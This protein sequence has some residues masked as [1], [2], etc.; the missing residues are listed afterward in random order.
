[1]LPSRSQL[2][3]LNLQP[4]YTLPR[5]TSTHAPIR[6]AADTG[7][8]ASAVGAIP[9]YHQLQTASRPHRCLAAHSGPATSSRLPMR[10]QLSLAAGALP[11]HDCTSIRVPLPLLQLTRH[12]RLQ[13]PSQRAPSCFSRIVFIV[14]VAAI[15]VGPVCGADVVPTRDWGLQ[16][17]A[18]SLVL[19]CDVASVPRLNST[20]VCPQGDGQA[21]SPWSAVG[22]GTPVNTR[23][24]SSFSIQLSGGSLWVCGPSPTPWVPAACPSHPRPA[25]WRWRGRRRFPAL[26]L[27]RLPHPVPLPRPHGRCGLTRAGG[28]CHSTPSRPRCGSGGGCWRGRACPRVP[29]PTRG[30]APARSPCPGVSLRVA[31]PV[32]TTEHNPEHAPGSVCCYNAAAP[33]PGICSGQHNGCGRRDGCWWWGQCV[34]THGGPGPA[35]GQCSVDCG[36]KFRPHKLPW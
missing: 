10:V 28:V 22:V 11:M 3:P 27:Q 7:G 31:L 2:Q 26:P 24:G 36:G 35:S 1:M 19:D 15:A 23:N 18:S 16:P 21:R 12:H 4:F 5:S 29:V 25:G 32:P 30:S 20:W 17:W 8:T 13:R 14:A 33:G 9:A 34:P 6:G